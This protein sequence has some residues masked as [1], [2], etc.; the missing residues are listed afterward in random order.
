VKFRVSV[1]REGVL[2]VSYVFWASRYS[3]MISVRPFLLPSPSTAPT[4]HKPPHPAATAYDP[5]HAAAPG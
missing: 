2:S 5:P 4:A 1:G 3:A